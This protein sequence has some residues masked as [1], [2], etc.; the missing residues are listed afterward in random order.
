M[1][2]RQL[3]PVNDDF[4]R[5]NMKTVI[6]SGSAIVLILVGAAFGQSGSGDSAAAKTSVATSSHNASKPE[7]APK[8]P[9]G[10][11]VVQDKDYIPVIDGV[12]RKLQS[13]REAFMM[14]DPAAAA[15]HVRA[16]AE[17][18]SKQTSGTTPGIKENV[19]GAMKQLDVAM[20]Q[21]NA[22]ATELDSK[23]TVGVKQ[24]DAVIAM[25]HRADLAT[26]WVEVDESSWY[27]YIEEPNRHFQNAHQAF[28]AKDYPKA[29]EEIRKGEAFVNM[30]ASRASG[31]VKQSLDSSA[32]ELERLAVDLTDNRREKS[33]VKMDQSWGRADR[34]LARSHQV[35]AKAS[36]R[37]KETAKAGYEM[38]AAAVNL[39]E[40]AGWAGSESKT[41]VSPVVRDTRSLAGKLIAGGEYAAGEVDK[42]ID[43]LGHAIS[44]LGQKN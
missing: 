30:E 21:L 43:D 28:L 32:Q 40:S 37:K 33:T 4:G 11:I 10:W 26:D 22:L 41:R 31:D 38:R 12:S 13:A 1:D 35:Q 14:K 2:R 36:W 20:K 8:I 24:F 7:I 15:T 16:A 23:K 18:L 25:A 34:A 29:A 42:G 17:L 3:R 9:A 44:G 6:L 5:I 39:D 27:P 19:D